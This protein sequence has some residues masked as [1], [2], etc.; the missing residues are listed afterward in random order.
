MTEA[1]IAA[2]V[3]VAQDMLYMYHLLE[4]LE[5]EVELPM[6]LEMDNSSAVDIANSWSVGGRMH[7]VDMR[8]Y[9]LRKLKD[10]GLLVIRHIAGES[11]D[12]DIFTKN[13]TSAEFNRHIPLYIGEDEYVSTHD[14]DL[15]G[16]FVSNQIYSSSV[17][18]YKIGFWVLQD[19]YKT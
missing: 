18:G 7:H 19:S 3:M 5:L 8:N 17:Q 12:A 16:E 10:Q 6:V 9:F 4:S 13:V 1:E 11:N 15:S 2:G 14:Q